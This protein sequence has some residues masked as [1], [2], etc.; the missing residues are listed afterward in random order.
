MMAAKLKRQQYDDLDI[1]FLRLEQLEKRLDM[2]ER[3]ITVGSTS[4]GQ[5]HQAQAA[6]QMPQQTEQLRQLLEQIL[7]QQ[8]QSQQ[9]PQPQQEPVTGGAQGGGGGCDAPPDLAT[10]RRRAAA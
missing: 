8:Q 7:L 10:S 5:G 1:I 3:M 4:N 6:V 9:Q 2:A